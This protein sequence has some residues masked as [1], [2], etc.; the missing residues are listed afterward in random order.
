MKKIMLIAG[1]SDLAGSEIDGTEDSTY[2]RQHSFG[3]LLAAKLG[4]EPINI[5]TNGPTNSGIARSVLEWF[6]QYYDAST[7]DVFVLVGWS[8][9]I[10][11]E[12]PVDWPTPYEMWNGAADWFTATSRDYLRVNMGWKGTDA[13]ELDIIARTQEF[14]AQNETYLEIYSANLVLQLQYFL[15]MHG[16]KYLMC[17]TLHMFTRGKHLDFYLSNIDAKQ[18]INFDNN[19]ECFY[20]KYR[21]AGHTNPKAK[22][23]HHGE[24]PHRLYADELY[25]FIQ[26]AN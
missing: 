19:D 9:S 14:M 5:A 26:N 16:V 10:R 25:N 13:R 20:W 15:K 22:Y 17:N 8:E 23:W 12:A 6:Q 18:Y 7:M 1:G 24:E 2:N 21:N 3:N 4:Y 11:V